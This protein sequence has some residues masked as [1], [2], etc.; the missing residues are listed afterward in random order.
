MYDVIQ[1]TEAFVWERLTP[2]ATGHDWPHVF[3]V[4]RNALLI[5]RE[6][7]ADLF[8]VEIT[9]LLHDI[10]DWKFYGGSDAAGPQVAREWLE[11]LQVNAAV[12]NEVCETIAR[13]SY[14]GAAVVAEPLSLAGQVVQDA[15]RLDAIGAIGIAR[16]FAYGGHKG[17]LMY[18]PEVPPLLH[19]S[20]ES[21]KKNTGPTLNH[22]YEKLLLL[23]DR[24]NTTTAKR[25]AEERHRLLETFVRQFL[26]EWNGND[27]LLTE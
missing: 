27:Q 23:R 15:D 5:A 20:F 16:A 1:Q 26:E 14:K 13:L 3:R 18:D 9:A 19:D 21:Y 24:L 6:E 22:F 17:R 8:V 25:L 7:G 10:A 4:R 11:K 2:D 12:I